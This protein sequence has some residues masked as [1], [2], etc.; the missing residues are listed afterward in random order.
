MGLFSPEG[1]RRPQLRLDRMLGRGQR[2]GQK[3]DE[4]RPGGAG[5]LLE[6]PFEKARKAAG[7]SAAL[8]RNA[9]SR[10]PF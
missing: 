9:R 7:K 10:L 1:S 5:R 6:A 4:K 2:A 3:A 8:G